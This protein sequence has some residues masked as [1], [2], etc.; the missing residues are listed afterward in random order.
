MKR[1][2][3]PLLMMVTCQIALAQLTADYNVIPLLKNIEVVNGAPF[4]LDNQTSICYTEQAEKRNAEFLAEYVEETIGLQLSV[5][6]QK[7]KDHYISISVNPA[8]NNPEGYQIKV[9]TKGIEVV[10]GSKPGV[11]Y[12]IQ[13]LRKSLPIIEKISPSTSVN[14]PAVFIQDE[15][16]F[17]Y[18]GMMLDC[19]RHFF[20]LDFVKEY[21]D[22]LAL[23]NMNTFH[24]HLT[25]DQGWRIE[26]KKYPRL[27]EFGSKRTGTVIGNNS[28]VDDRVP[29]GGFYTQEEA[30]EIVAYAAERHISVIPEVDMPGHMK[31]ALACY[32]ELGCTGGPYEVGHKW[33]VYNDVLCVGNPK[34]YDFVKEVLDEIIQIFPS[35]VIHIGGDEAPTVRW[36]N[37]PKCKALELNG[38]T[39]QGYFTKVVMDHLASKGRRIIGWDELVENG[40]SQSATIMGWRG[41]LPGWPGEKAAEAGYDVVMA[42]ATHCYFDYYQ[43]EER[44]YEPSI[45]GIWPISVEKVYKL[46]PVP[47]SLSV[48]AKQHILGVQANLWTEYIAYPQVA[49]YM[50]LPRMAA[51]SEVAWTDESNKDF[52]R[53]KA[54]LNRLVLYYEFKGWTYAKH[55]WPERMSQDRWHN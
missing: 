8:I 27:T 29:Y 46:N 21:I 52:E 11:F 12:G 23:H 38:Q 55:L 50:V 53:F 35:E 45:T 44:T 47:D 33:G 16:R 36:D 39:K 31:T 2:I 19:A 34:V 5:S 54:R 51:L 25:D 15:P 48:S 6:N 26:I 32:P 24:W 18:R 40:A 30:R 20:S 22:L 13:T 3:I 28:D 41:Q 1:T 14:L 49:E 43:T 7:P 9:S 4:V 37:C 42:P 10:G 17:G